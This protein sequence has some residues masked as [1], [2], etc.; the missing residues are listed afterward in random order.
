M[1]NVL[2]F[3]GREFDPETNLYYNRARYYDPQLARFLSEDPI[4][5]SGGVNQYAYA[6]NNPIGGAD[7]SGEQCDYWNPGGGDNGQTMDYGYCSPMPDGM[8]NP[9]GGHPSCDDRGPV[10]I[11]GGAPDLGYSPCQGDIF[12]NFTGEDIT[13]DAARGMKAYLAQQQNE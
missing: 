3:A 12:D 11:N 2:K 8:Y 6:G 10:S 1:P 7:P 5:Q 9:P 13:A 4:G